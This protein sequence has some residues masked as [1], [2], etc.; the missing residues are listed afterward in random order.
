MTGKVYLIGAGPGD[1]GL[2]T[3][4]GL[5]RLQ[6]ADVVVYDRLV[7][8]RLMDRAR[9]GAELVFVGKGPGELV[10]EQEEINQY[11]VKGGQ[12]GKVIARLKGGDPFVFGR[13]GEEAQALAMSGIPFEVVPGV[14]SAI[15]APAYAGIPLTHRQ[16]ASSFTVISGSED[17]S[18]E[19]SSI[20]WDMLAQSGGTLVVLMGWGALDKITDTLIKV[21]KERSTPVALVHW[22]TEPYQLTVTGTLEDIGRRGKDAGLTPPVV[23]V[24]GEVVELRQ[25]LR[26]FEKGPLFGKRVLVTRSRNQASALSEMLAEG[27]A[28][29]IEVSTIEFSEVEDYSTVDRAIAALRKYSWVIFTST[30]GVEAFFARLQALEGDSRSLA[31]IKVGAIGPATS[32][33]LAQHG[34]KADF[35]PHQYLSEAIVQ[36]METQDLRGARV[37]LPRADIGRDDL[38]EGLTRLGAEVEQVSVYR[39]IMPQDFSEKAKD[40]LSGGTI[41]LVTFTSSST[42][43]NLL[44]L[45]DGNSSLLS[46]PLIACIGPVTASTA[47]DMGLHVDVVAHEHT[48]AGLVSAV[49]KYFASKEL[50]QDGKLS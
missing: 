7:D 37:L 24:I 28:E 19:E 40:L 23:A 34:I 48:V 8:K 25:E 3:V 1:P 33:A 12:E 30:N 32:T 39:T 50:D 47:R 38:A 21:G 35:V 10:M 26:W 44:S 29:P 17:P 9:K 41:D 4:K 49:K 42:V 45:L 11:L 5:R 43:V 20:R 22:G 2:I 13:G 31:G 46:T 6:E 18:K 16:L 14:T 36:G 27:G 15:A